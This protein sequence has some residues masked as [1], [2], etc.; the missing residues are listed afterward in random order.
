MM[1]IILSMGMAWLVKYSLKKSRGLRRLACSSISYCLVECHL[2]IL[3]SLFSLT[4][5]NPGTIVCNGS[6]MSSLTISSRKLSTDTGSCDSLSTNLSLLCT[7]FYKGTIQ[8]LFKMTSATRKYVGELWLS[9]WGRN[10]KTIESAPLVRNILPNSSRINILWKRCTCYGPIRTNLM[11]SLSTFLSMS[12]LKTWFEQYWSPVIKG[13]LTS[14]QSL[15]I[16]L[17]FSMS[18]A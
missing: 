2:I 13:P 14:K 15:S 11:P 3:T 9:F 1:P 10:C 6:V 17:P 8:S 4:P 5:M 7:I 12:F 16:L 18:R